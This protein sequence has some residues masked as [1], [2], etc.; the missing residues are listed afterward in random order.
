[1]KE[2][3]NNSMSQIGMSAARI[4]NAKPEKKKKTSSAMQHR[5]RLRAINNGRQERT[6]AENRQAR[7]SQE[8]GYI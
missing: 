4:I 8:R 3:K 6:G 7:P 1:M 2:G 5:R